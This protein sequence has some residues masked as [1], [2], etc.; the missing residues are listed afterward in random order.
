VKGAVDQERWNLYGRERSASI[1]RAPEDH[2]LRQNPIGHWAVHDDLMRLLGSLAGKAILEVGSGRGE[3]AVWLSKCGARVAG[4]DIG[5][6]LVEAAS[7]LARVNAVECTFAQGSLVDMS[8]DSESYD[9]VVGLG[10]L[11]HL[12]PAAVRKGL[13]ECRRVLKDGGLALFHEPVENSAAFD[14]LQNL[15]PAGRQGDPDYRPSVLRRSAWRAYRQ[16]LD[17]RSMTRRELLA[18][19]ECFS[20]ARTIPYGILV[21]LQRLVGSRHRLWLTRTDRWLLRVLPPLGYFSQS[22]LAV[23]RK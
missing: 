10:V 16:A 22:M 1:L 21:R 6:D 2:V 23:Y 14:L 20:S 3:F 5:P 19:G 4:I 15:L 13:C 17:D 12:P 18:A 11:H 8:A 7:R 9:V